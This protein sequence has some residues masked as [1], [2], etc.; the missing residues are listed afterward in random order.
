M[1]IIGFP[2]RQ[3]LNVKDC[4][5]TCLQLIAEFYGKKYS[6]QTL[7]EYS[8]ISREGSSLMGLSDAAERIGF[9]TLGLCLGY[10]KLFKD[11]KLPC[12]L[13]WNNNHYVICYKIKQR[14]N[15]HEF[16]I[17]DPASMKYICNESDF[18]K[19]WINTIRNNEER[20]IVLS[21]VP[22]ATFYECEDEGTLGRSH[23]ITRYMRYL[24]PHKSGVIQNIICLIIYMILGLA[25]PFL[26]QSVV[27]VGIKGSNLDFVVLILIAQLILALTSMGIGLVNSWVSIHMTTRINISLIADFWSKLLKLPAKFYDIKVTGDIMQRFGDYSRIQDFL[28]HSTIKIAFSA[29]NFVIYTVI[30]AYYNYRILTIFFAGQFLYVLWTLCFLK[31]WKKL[32]YQNFEISAKNKNKTLQML[33]GVLDIKLSNEERQKRWEWEKIQAKLFRVY[34]KSMKLRQLQN[35]IG[36]LI[37]NITYILLSYIVAKNVI[38][39]EMT[40]GMMMAITY[41]TGQI[42]GPVNDFVGFI[43]SLQYTKISLERLNEINDSVDD[44]T[45][46]QTKRTDMPDNQSLHFNHVSFSYDG[47]PRRYV[48]KDVSF[49]IPEK[50]VTAIVGSS[51]CGKTTI[52]KLLQGLYAP[53]EGVVSVDSTPIVQMNP[54][55]W[56]KHI[57]A[58]MQDGY[59]FSE[60]IARNIATGDLE[61]DKERL[62]YAAK[63]A[64]IIDFI[65]K[66]PLGYNMKIGMEG[67]GISQGQRQRVLIARAT[68]KNP[69]IFLF[70][71]ATNALDSKNEKE[72]MKNLSECFEGKTVVI[73]AHRLSTIRNADQIIVM[74]DGTIAEVGNHESLMKNKGAY[75][76][77]V[78]SQL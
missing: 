2:H 52:M 66:N 18:K 46:I 34:F 45:N 64:N 69:D 37:T 48:L 28:L 73:A 30:L 23:D 12:I 32:D 57:G 65:D 67:T 74:R 50:K 40:L 72:I 56:R 47:S 43:Q 20:G 22:G 70:D 76:E 36:S 10:D 62:R 3:Q 33:Q 53:T 6:L 54:H 7:R 8:C 55:L 9:H 15:G 78:E 19:H 24:T 59:I 68:Y 11:V 58:V 51:G 17:S 77:L 5:A 39:G 16:Y 38:D 13:F 35:I 31:Q 60:T 41:I 44:D 21:L 14:R 61:I 29:V 1:K 71:E 42:G 75:Y 27:D 25:T 4:G 49:D 26:T 63:I